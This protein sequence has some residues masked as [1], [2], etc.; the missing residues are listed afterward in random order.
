LS[1][2]VSFEDLLLQLMC[3]FL[4]TAVLASN[5][6][7][8]HNTICTVTAVGRRSLSSLVMRAYFISTGRGGGGHRRAGRARSAVPGALGGAQGQGKRAAASARA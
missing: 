2:F 8:V 1:F 3:L 4:A 5:S 6:V 7:P